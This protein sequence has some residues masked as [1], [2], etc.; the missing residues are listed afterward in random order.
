MR[1]M[2]DFFPGGPDAVIVSDGDG[3]RPAIAKAPTS[4]SVPSVFPPGTE[5]WLLP[6]LLAFEWEVPLLWGPMFLPEALPKP[7]SDWLRLAWDLAHCR[8]VGDTCSAD[9]LRAAGVDLPV[10][11][12]PDFRVLAAESVPAHRLWHAW[13]QVVAHPPHPGTPTLCVELDAETVGEQGEELQAGLRE[14]A[15]QHFRRIV[16]LAVPGSGRTPSADE[17]SAIHNLVRALG[18]DTI[19]VNRQLSALEQSALIWGAD[20]C[21]ASSW[22]TCWSAVAFQKPYLML[23]GQHAHRGH[24][25]LLPERV[26]GSPANLPARMGALVPAQKPI[27]TELQ[28]KLSLAAHRHLDHMAD[29]LSAASRRQRPPR[30]IV[31]D[32]R[33]PRLDACQALLAPLAMTA[34]AIWNT[35]AAAQRKRLRSL[36][37]RLKRAHERSATLRRQYEGYYN[38]WRF[39]LVERLHQAMR[40]LPLGLS[41]NFW[42]KRALLW[43]WHR[44]RGWDSEP[45]AMARYFE[46]RYFLE[47][48]MRWLLKPDTTR[49]LRHYLVEEFKEMWLGGRSLDL[50]TWFQRCRPGPELLERFRAQS[51]P[52][53]APFFTVIVRMNGSS[54]EWLHET[55]NSLAVQTYRN[56]EA[57]LVV[58]EE[59]LSSETHS[60]LQTDSARLQ[61]CY[62]HVSSQAALSEA[63]GDYVCLLEHGDALEP[64]ALHRI[65]YALLDTRAGLLYSD[66]VTTGA[67]LDDVQTLCARPAFSYDYFLSHRYIDHLLAVQTN[68]L[69]DAGGFDCGADVDADTD[70]LLRVLEK[71]PSVS[72]VPDILYRRRTLLPPDALGERRRGAVAQHLER[73]GVAVELASTDHPG[74]I[75]VRWTG[76]RQGTTAIVIPSKDQNELLRT[77][78]DSLHRTILAEHVH[79]CVVD[80]E[81]R[82]PRALEFLE[83]LRRQHQV[84]PYRGA[85]NFS[86]LMNHGVAQLARACDY[87]LF[88]N[89]DVE[90]LAPGWLEHMLGIAQRREVGA[91][92]ALL[93]YPDGTV[94]HAGAVVGLHM[95][96]DHLFRRV[97]AFTSAGRRRPGSDML[98]LA[99]RDQSIVTAACLLVR[100]D[101]FHAVGGFDPALGVG[102]GDSDLCLRIRARGLKVILDNQAVLVHHESVSRGQSAR[103]D[104]HPLDTQLFRAR[105]LDLIMTGDPYY[106]PLLSRRF[107]HGLNP[108][109]RAREEVKARTVPMVLPASVAAAT[110]AEPV[111]A[112]RRANAATC[113][114]RVG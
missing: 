31:W 95:A 14:L 57:R 59:P 32:E 102:F 96:A 108:Y 18:K 37:Q 61:R 64:H 69:R 51:W 88:L 91:V 58:P 94:Q 73:L 10:E 35:Q 42:L 6:A 54:D 63:L 74:C 110:A 27:L 30:L 40:K 81:T 3:I 34:A 13:K 50:G 79:L 68:L 53:E 70:W 16:V 104:P 4:G 75:D 84:V 92:G 39:R 52:D 112:S 100:A 19:L 29:L 15:R 36:E 66:A 78:V 80:H 106:S 60:T 107:S 8:W 28:E 97:P 38:A 71:S 103:E 1:A 98:L 82:E 114:K 90:A 76:P 17:R 33:G 83:Q 105:Y 111:P 22:H 20:A 44:V 72:H 86:R 89:N 65:A 101:V 62:T 41:L 46:R 93:L 23:T 87:Y 26:A 67:D 49:A 7:D 9:G 43:L 85:F 12:V 24:A 21:V 99:P 113:L 2:A 11:V 77:C 56:W 25:D 55:L 109:A 47:P 5:S 45:K 48:A